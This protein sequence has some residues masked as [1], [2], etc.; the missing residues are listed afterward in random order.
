MASDLTLREIRDA[1]ER[2]AGIAVRTPLVPAPSLAGEAGRDVRLKLEITQPIGAFKLRGAANA[3]ATLPDEARRA[4]V[5]CVSTGNHGRALAYA[6]RRLG[7]S[8]TVCMSSLVPRVKVEGIRALGADVRIVGESQDDAQVEVDRLVARAGMT[9]IHPFDRREVIAG[10]GTIGLEIL[11]DMPEVDTVVV[12][13]SGG[14]LIGGIALAIKSLR[15]R[16]RIVGASIERGAAMYESVA[17]GKI[18]PVTEEPTARV[19]AELPEKSCRAPVPSMN[20]PSLVPSLIPPRSNVPVWI[21]TVPLLLNPVAKE[22]VPAL[23][24]RMSEPV[25]LTSGRG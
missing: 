13:L 5:V 20:A 18:V 12:P 21:S 22:T 17:A 11:E 24:A 15:P 14:G 4:G 3:L 25:M 8:S 10:Q 19:C 16:T 2:I 23:P 7:L 9:E 6:A 1:R